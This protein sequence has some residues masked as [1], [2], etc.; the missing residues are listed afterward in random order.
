[1]QHNFELRRNVAPP[2]GRAVGD[3]MSYLIGL[4]IE[5]STSA[6]IGNQSPLRHPAKKQQKAYSS[7][8]INWDKEKTLSRSKIGQKRVLYLAP[9]ISIK[10]F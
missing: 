5:P 7:V 8:R 3:T 6:P 1:M 4:E 2:T 10:Q 9:I